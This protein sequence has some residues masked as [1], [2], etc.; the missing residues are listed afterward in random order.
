MQL[1]QEALRFWVQRPRP[2]G[3]DYQQRFLAAGQETPVESKRPGKPKGVPSGAG[4]EG[5]EGDER[6][7]QGLRIG[8]RIRLYRVQQ[9]CE[10][11]RLEYL[12]SVHWSLITL[13]LC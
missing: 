2:R 12:S 1:Q 13:V 5:S 9:R 11:S 8:R 4:W 10:P 6:S 3:F 7:G